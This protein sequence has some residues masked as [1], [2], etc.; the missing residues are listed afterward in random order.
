MKKY[1]AYPV[2]VVWC[3]LVSIAAQAESISLK[4]AER[5][6]LKNNLNL[7]AQT[8]ET[9]ASEALVRG[10]YGI[11]DPLAEM[12]LADGVGRERLNFQFY[13]AVSKEEYR[14]FDFSLTQKI[15]TGAELIASFTN[16]RDAKKPANVIDPSY[17]S[18]LRFTL[19][20]PLL[21]NLG[22]EMT[23]RDILFAIEDRNASLQD[24]RESAFNLITE[25]RKAFFD[26][27]RFRDNLAYRETS[28]ALAEKVLKENG[29]RVD[30]GV[31]APVE[32]LEAEVGLQQRERDLLNARRDYDD[33]LDRLALLLNLTN[34]LEVAAVALD[35]PVLETSEEQGLRAALEKRPD[36]QRRQSEIERLNLERRVAKNQLLP[37]LDFSASFAHKGL[38]KDYSDDL[39]DIASTDFRNWEVG[40]KLSYPLGNRKA[41]NDYQRSDLRLK[42][43]HAQLAQLREEVQ[44]EIR[45]AIRLLDV[46][47]KIIEV[48]SRGRDLSEEKLRTLLKR[49]EV[50]LATTRQVLEGEDDLARARTD[51]IAA[52]ADYNNASTEYL[53]VTGLLLER[54]GVHFTGS[55]DEL[56]DPSLH[57][58]PRL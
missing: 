17:G 28:V 1:I 43:R 20:Q 54:E 11:Y 45:S 36:L 9:R 39:D 49:K 8:Y 35:Q 52:L 48:T 23:E 6:A 33:A 50:G 2:G 3:C 14:R 47:K 5:L 30:A 41:R 32:I 56:I 42:G 40:V 19:V 57:E 37:A 10:G 34:G 15:P 12:E 4:E 7:R 31:L 55:L 58:S 16:R 25:V 53:R 18:E 13:G 24:L 44:T 38:G 26:V 27:L 29:A 22:R 51:Q 46:S 21:K